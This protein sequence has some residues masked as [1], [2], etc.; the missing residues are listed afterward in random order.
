MCRIR[1][2]IIGNIVTAIL[3]LASFSEGS[4]NLKA[5]EEV[6]SIAYR[7]CLAPSQPIRIAMSEN[8]QAAITEC[9]KWSSVEQMSMEIKP[10]GYM[11]RNNSKGRNNPLNAFLNHV[12]STVY[13]VS[14][15]PSDSYTTKRLYSGFQSYG[16]QELQ[17]FQSKAG[18]LIIWPG[19]AGFIIE[20]TS[21]PEQRI[22]DRLAGLS[23]L[24][25][26]NENNGLLQV[27]TATGLQ[28][29]L[30][31]TPPPRIIVPLPAKT[32]FW[33]SWIEQDL[34]TRDIVS[35]HVLTKG[36]SYNIMLDLSRFNYAEVNQQDPGSPNEVTQDYIDKLLSKH[37][38]IRFLVTPVG[39][40]L[41]PIEMPIVH[42]RFVNQ[43]RLQ[44]AP[45]T[46]RM[47]NQSISDFAQ[48]ASALDDPS[49]WSTRP[50]TVKVD[51]H[52]VGC[53][54]LAFSVW[55]TSLSRLIDYVVRTVAIR[56]DDVTPECSPTSEVAVPPDVPRLGMLSLES[57][58]EAN[59]SLH[60]FERPVPA[61]TATIVVYAQDNFAVPYSW[62]ISARLSDIETHL[63]N[64]LAEHAS[65]ASPQLYA[66]EMSSIIDSHLFEPLSD[67]YREQAKQ[68]REGLQQLAAKADG[69]RPSIFV[70]FANAQNQRVFIPIH[71]LLVDLDSPQPIGAKIDII[72]PLTPPHS[73]TPEGDICLRN[74]HIFISP[75]EIDIM[76]QTIDVNAKLEEISAPWG[77][78][79][80]NNPTTAWSD[81]VA[82]VRS[83]SRPSE[84]EALLLLAHHGQ[85][86]I[87]FIKNQP[88]APVMST[89]IKRSFLPGSVAV[90]A[91]CSV[92]NISEENKSRQILTHLSRQGIG[93]AIVSPFTV[94]NVIGA[95]LIIAFAKHVNAARGSNEEV[96]IEKLFSDTINDIISNTSL[97]YIDRL[98]AQEFM[99]IGN[100]AVKI[101]KEG[102]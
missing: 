13:K 97:G 64:Y 27:T 57:Y 68:A 45:S 70:R 88:Q 17:S 39:H 6:I 50:I 20:D 55:D 42:R 74:M 82:Y 91:A 28:Q 37:K 24:H 52:E 61:N 40:G 80:Y 41:T 30:G 23:I 67:D 65:G 12:I 48:G 14:I 46:G 83:T 51:A 79:V 16:W 7:T 60:I 3:L 87:A 54:G 59:A 86:E 95:H 19:M 92:A 73:L 90:L 75:N 84:S 49:D 10:E 69:Q 66:R 101:C 76:K 18:A 96:T 93:S 29:S 43:K 9:E 100:G 22:K 1:R 15:R 58:R 33:N 35:D 71:L 47:V 72:H 36:T 11:A 38:E 62:P 44:H 77:L 85:D 53:A 31:K 56:S 32:I 102:R 26:S 2:S 34:P 81:F 63:K 98:R 21:L 5:G 25:P 99:L 4:R 78:K 89:T 8:D 94:P